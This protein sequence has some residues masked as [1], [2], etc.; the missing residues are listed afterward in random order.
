MPDFIPVVIHNLKGY[1]THY[2]SQEIGNVREKIKCIPNTMEKYIS[3]SVGRLRFVDSL[4]FLNAFLDTFTENLK[5]G[6]NDK[7]KS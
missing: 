1:D 6:G 3:F 7:L 2:I 4:Q 5:K